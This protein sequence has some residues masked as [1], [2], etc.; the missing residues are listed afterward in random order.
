MN[1]IAISNQ[2]KARKASDVIPREKEPASEGKAPRPINA[3]VGREAEA[4][5]GHENLSEP[6]ESNHAFEGRGRVL[7]GEST[8]LLCPR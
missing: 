7:V 5:N 3:G 2:G 8:S 4:I 1:R 6:G